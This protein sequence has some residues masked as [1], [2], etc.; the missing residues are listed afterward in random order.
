MTKAEVRLR[1]IRCV[2]NLRK[3]GCTTNDRIAVIARNNHNLTPLLFA[4]F[5]NGSPLSPLDVVT[6]KGLF[7]IASPRLCSE[8]FFEHLRK[9][10]QEYPVTSSSISDGASHIIQ[11]VEPSFIFCDA[12]ELLSVKQI[13]DDIGLSAKLFT[14]NGSVDGYDSIDEL[15]SATGDEDSFVYVFVVICSFLIFILNEK[16]NHDNAINFSLSAVRKS[17]MYFHM[18]QYTRAPLVRLGSQNRFVCL[19][20]F[21]FICSPFEWMNLLL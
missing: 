13:I 14:V 7:L 9:K 10:S 16:L 12:D 11:R 20:H 1:T 21:S 8:M 15:M 3:L 18:R 6:V 2:Q 19:M 17:L 4:A 5:C